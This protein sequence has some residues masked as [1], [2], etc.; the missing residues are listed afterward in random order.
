MDRI[1]VSCLPSAFCPGPLPHPGRG[2][3]REHAEPVRARPKVWRLVRRVVDWR[4]RVERGHPQHRRPGRIDLAAA[5]SAWACWS[6]GHP[7]SPRVTPGH[8]A[9][10]GVLIVLGAQQGGNYRTGEVGTGSSRTRGRSPVRALFGTSLVV[11]ATARCPP[12]SATNR[13]RISAGLGVRGRHTA[14]RL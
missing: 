14:L 5:V 2:S 3:P 1:A 7:G 11:P 6:P 12:N 4:G 8:P 13:R 10:T 9:L